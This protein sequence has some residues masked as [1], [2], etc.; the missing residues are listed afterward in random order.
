MSAAYIFYRIQ[1]YN[2]VVQ[3]KERVLRL[4]EDKNKKCLDLETE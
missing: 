4:I 1:D 2:D 3:E